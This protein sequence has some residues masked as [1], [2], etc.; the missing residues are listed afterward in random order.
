MSWG[1]GSWGGSAAWGTGVT[2]PPP[3]LIGVSSDPGPTAPRTGPAVVDVLGGTVCLLLGTNF[4][5]PMT[6]DIGLGVGGGFTAL[7]RGY[8]FDPEFDLEANRV[9]FGAPALEAG[10]YNVRVTTGGGESGVLAGALAARPFADEYKVASVRGKFST[11]W[12]TGPRIL[13]GS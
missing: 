2:L 12:A 5:D 10:L 11:K 1:T 3:A 6:I 7:A 13:R 8:I 9:Y 4:V